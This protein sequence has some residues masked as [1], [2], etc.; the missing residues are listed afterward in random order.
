[1]MILDADVY[2]SGRAD[3]SVRGGQIAAI[4]RL[5]PAAGERV[6]DARGGALLPGL[7]DHHIHLLSFAASFSS[8]RCG[9]PEIRNETELAAALRRRRAEYPG[10]W[11]RGYGY[12]ESVA[13]D[14]DRRWLDRCLPDTPVRIQHR[15]GRL[16]ILNSAAL[17]LLAA[18]AETLPA[19]AAPEIDGADTGQ[20]FDQDA[21]LQRL[22]G[23]N[24]PDVG[25]ASRALARCGV[26]GITDMTPNNDP[27]SA[28]TLSDLQSQ[29]VLLQRV[30]LA[31]SLGL[32]GASQAETIRGVGPMLDIGPTKVHLHESGLPDFQSLCRTMA[33]SHECGRSVA[34]HC[35]TETE[36][37]FTLA[38]FGEAGT[39]AGDRV[40]HASVTP[41]A[42]LEQLRRLGLVVVTQPNFVA[43]RGDAYL[44][45]LAPEDLPALY[46]CRSF[47][48]QGVPLAG[49]TD[50]PFGNADPWYAMRAATRRQT[51]NGRLLGAA[52]ALDPEQA[53]A[54]F[55]G[56]PAAPHRAR[57]IEPG[58]AAD[59]CLLDRSWAAA[60]T[61]LSADCVRA[62]IRGG[63]LIYD[64]VDEAPFQRPGR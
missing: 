57:R 31:G 46:R 19:G 43:E 62:T 39:V 58:A 55:L 29:G 59:L 14:I 35:V 3:V 11:I 13:G 54:L 18:T 45:D 7:H 34:V 42:L 33:L 23:R 32:S 50:A 17:A 21:V 49:G 64:G 8:L 12:H 16:W 10:A 24:L 44:K 41:P 61:R 1:M 15:S 30:C 52:E 60:R 47:L 25:A 63:D 9:P 36:L 53:L 20:L 2:G 22:L 40:E 26:T 38:A 28:A 6:L 5:Q 4:G 37:V 48:E 27:D 51:A 56:S